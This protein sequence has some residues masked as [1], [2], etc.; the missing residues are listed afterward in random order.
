M[1]VPQHTKTYFIYLSLQK[2]TTRNE[3]KI[4]KDNVF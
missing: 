2:Q 1:S 4:G 3:V